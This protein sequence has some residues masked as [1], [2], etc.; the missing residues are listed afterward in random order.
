[1]MIPAGSTTPPRVT[2]LV[3]TMLAARRHVTKSAAVTTNRQL[4]VS[5][6]G[7]SLEDTRARYPRSRGPVQSHAPQR[8]EKR[9]ST[10]GLSSCIPGVLYGLDPLGSLTLPLDASIVPANDQSEERRETFVRRDQPIARGLCPTRSI[11]NF[12]GRGAR[13]TECE[14]PTSHEAFPCEVPASRVTGR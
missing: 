13:H 8:R 12:L 6:N 9:I 3:A 7:D 14:L 4:N 2:S 11:A 10:L 5:G 1:M